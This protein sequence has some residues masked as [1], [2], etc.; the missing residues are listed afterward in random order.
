MFREAFAASVGPTRAGG[1]HRVAARELASR[2]SADPMRVAHHAELGADPLLAAEALTDAAA[3]A[4]QRYEHAEALAL[5]DRALR[6]DDT[7]P[8]RLARARVLLLLG[9]Y[10]EAQVEVDDA[11]AR[12]AGAAALE[13][14]ALA[15][16]FQR[17]LELALELAD[18][19]ARTATEPDHVVGCWCLAGRA[20]LTLGRLDEAL[21]R[22]HEAADLA[23]GP[24]RA[25]AA[26]WTAMTLAMRGGGPDAYRLAR[27]AATARNDPAV[28]PYRALALGRAL[29]T[30]DRPYE[31]LQVFEHLDEV[32]QRQQVAR[33]AGRSDNYRSWVLRNL[34]ATEEADAATAAAWD[35]VGDL[36]DLA[37]A[38][39]HGHA[40]LD[41][42]DAAL[43]TGDLA[44]A[45]TW[46]DRMSSAPTTP[47]VMRWRIDLR[48][49]LL[50]GRLALAADDPDRAA[51]LAQQVRR[52]AGRLGVPRYAHLADALAAR[53]VLSRKETLD[54]AAL[55]RTAELLGPS[56]PLESWWLIGELARDTGERRFH[57]LAAQR[58]DALLAGAGPYTDRLRAAA[59]QLLEG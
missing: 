56:A 47:H 4:G 25:V 35:A 22:L 15:A 1:W 24:L 10:D 6:L 5:L 2:R 33:F 50:H 13:L 32:V 28:E 42:A 51:D 45:R 37:H 30:L 18:E 59:H 14:A 17:D 58:V 52:E 9:R 54:L 19:G 29:T 16:Y 57:E 21:E 43:R 46:L 41:L 12:G 31:A 34:G 55:E 38:E 27:G 44:A 36:R 40:L 23:S 53:V 11:L 8:R 49:D 39:A 20:L 3:L 7:V 26:T 48:H